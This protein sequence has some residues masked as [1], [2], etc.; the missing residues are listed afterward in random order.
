[1]NFLML[2]VLL[3][4]KYKKPTIVNKNA[5]IFNGLSLFIL[6]NPVMKNRPG[7][8]KLNIVSLNAAII[9]KTRVRSSIYTAAHTINDKNVMQTL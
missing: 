6:D 2:N 8:T 1:M 4:K 3:M 7:N 9:P 5:P